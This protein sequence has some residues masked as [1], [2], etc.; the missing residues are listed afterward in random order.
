MPTKPEVQQPANTAT[1]RRE[2][3]TFRKGQSGNPSGRPRSDSAALRTKLAEHGEAV[4]QIVIDQ[5]LAGDMTAAKLV[6]DRLAAPLR[7]VAPPVALDLPAD[8]VTPAG[9]A[10]AILRASTDGKISTDDA[11]R[12]ITA[13]GSLASLDQFDRLRERL[14]A[15]EKA[16]THR[17]P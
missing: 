4:A 3:G 16:L 10:A 5:A 7:A 14:D 13:C 8:A 6:L 1:S 2:D 17:S 9:I 11:S 15:L 12:L